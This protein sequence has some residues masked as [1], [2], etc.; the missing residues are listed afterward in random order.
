MY[1][2]IC[3]YLFCEPPSQSIVYAWYKNI[4]Y[5]FLA[6]AYPFTVFCSNQHYIMQKLN[7][8]G[9]IK[10][11]SF[12]SIFGG[13]LSTFLDSLWLFPKQGNLLQ[14]Q[15]RTRKTVIKIN[16][17]QWFPTCMRSFI[18]WRIKRVTS[19]LPIW[20][21]HGLVLRA[22]SLSCW[23]HLLGRL[24][25]L[26]KFCPSREVALQYLLGLHQVYIMHSQVTSSR[27]WGSYRFTWFGAL[28][29]NDW[30]LPY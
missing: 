8:R 7:C 15:L 20:L 19:P 10:G 4:S 24:H 22:C 12:A 6:G 1:I 16:G 11:R 9:W 26:H 13:Y 27:F 2:Y 21:S 3:I 28:S 14:S 30:T 5:R 17:Y 18:L 25:Y 29:Q 23:A